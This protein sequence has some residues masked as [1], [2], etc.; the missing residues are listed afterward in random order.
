ME[1]SS[2]VLLNISSLPG[3]FGIGGFSIDAK[4]FIEYITTMGMQ[5]WQILPLTTIGNGNSPYSGLSAF[6]GNFLYIDPYNIEEGLLTHEEIHQ[7]KYTG[8]HYLT[9]YDYAYKIKKELLQKAYSRLTAEIKEKMLEFSRKHSFWLEDYCLFMALREHFDNKPWYEWED[10]FKFREEKSIEWAKQNLA[11]NINFYLFEQYEFFTQWYKIKGFAK[12]CDV[13]IFGDMPIYVCLQSVDVWAN[14]QLF[15]LDKDLKP[16]VVAGVPPDYFAEDGQLWGNP[17]FDYKKMKKTNY[18]WLIKRILHNFELYDMLRVDHFRGLHQYWAVPIGS[19]TAKEGEWRDGPGMSLWKELNKHLPN[20][21]IIA[22]DLGFI[23]EG[24]RAYLKQTGFYGM[25]VMQFAFDNDTKN[26]HLP[27]NYNKK[28]VGYTGTHD[29]DT[30]L[31][32]LMSLSHDKRERV[33]RYVN[34][35]ERGWAGGDGSCPATKAFIH[36]LLASSCDLAIVPMQDLCGYGSDTRMN[37]PGKAEGNWEYRTNYTAMDSV[38]R[39][40]I[41]EQNTLYGRTNTSLTLC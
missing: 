21:N 28:C 40:F 23:D 38:D 3:E 24:V 39:S 14:T 1:R 18:E 13:G 34:C 29:N 30:T 17:I 4:N 12:S 36:A 25:R 2:G 11:D 22:E 37:V 26:T 7:A 35:D 5:W 27:H 20:P 16:C 10:G 8:S 6:A 9:D 31:G 41:M 15:Q 32:W 33:L 19:K